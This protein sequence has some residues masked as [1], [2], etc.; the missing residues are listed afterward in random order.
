M[1]LEK[2]S[3]TGLKRLQDGLDVLLRTE[4]QDSFLGVLKK[5]QQIRFIMTSF[6]TKK[7]RIS[8]YVKG[9]TYYDL[10]CLYGV[11]RLLLT[12]LFI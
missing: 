2:F 12:I 5:Y 3:D 11:A 8:C 7:E 1:K 4:N 6:L 10:S 9:S